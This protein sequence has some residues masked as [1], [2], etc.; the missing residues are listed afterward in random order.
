MANKKNITKQTLAS[1]VTAKVGL[2]KSHADE[3]VDLFFKTIIQGLEEDGVVKIS[4]FGTFSIL[5]KKER[6]GRNP[7]SLEDAIINSRKVVSF[8]ASDII[9][10]K[11]NK[12]DNE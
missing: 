6:L 2:S 7:K 9:R 1:A 8:K 4:R 11:I 12:R 3:L 10:N 5:N